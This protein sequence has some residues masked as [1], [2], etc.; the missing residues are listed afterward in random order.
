MSS[1][2]T[3]NFSSEFKS[4][5]DWIECIKLLQEA[6]ITAVVNDIQSR[7]TALQISK[8]HLIIS[9]PTQNNNYYV[10]Q[11]PETGKHRN[12]GIQ[13]LR[14][15]IESATSNQSQ[16]QIYQQRRNKSE[17]QELFT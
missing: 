1:A 14:H 11:D 3:F 10:V 5:E 7:D 6:R 12:V 2:L 9:T 8:P 17:E 4:E 13:L 16:Q 15:A